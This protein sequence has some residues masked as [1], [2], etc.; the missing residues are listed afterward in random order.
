[1]GDERKNP[2]VEPGWWRWRRR[3]EIVL[4]TD[5]ERR[6]L[7]EPQPSA[8]IIKGDADFQIRKSIY[9]KGD[10]DF[11]SISVFIKG[12]TSLIANRQVFIKGDVVFV[13]FAVYIKGDALLRTN[14]PL[15]DLGGNPAA[16]KPGA[17]SRTWLQV[18]SVTKDVT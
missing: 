4:N 2:T 18:K 17:I 6:V 14:V 13:S 16:T 9:V 8:I 3:W 5:W 10:T 15:P 1:M 11:T 7:G 12:D